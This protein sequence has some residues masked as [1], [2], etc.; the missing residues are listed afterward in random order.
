MN[1]T[2]KTLRLNGVQYN[3]NRDPQFYRRLPNQ[4]F[5]IQAN[6]QGVG[7][8][9]V[10]LFVENEKKLEQTVALPG[11]FEGSVSFDKPGSHIATLVIDQNGDITETH[12]RLD[13]MAHAWVG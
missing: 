9:K 5:S 12:L 8:A 10:S 3:A 1:Q 7:T 13:V 4:A 11:Q 6:I 2:I